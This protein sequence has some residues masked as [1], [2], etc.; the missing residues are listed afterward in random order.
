LIKKEKNESERERC[1]RKKRTRTHLIERWGRLLNH[2]RQQQTYA[3]I[4]VGRGR[5]SGDRRWQRPVVTVEIVYAMRI[6]IPIPVPTKT[7]VIKEKFWAPK[8]RVFHRSNTF[9]HH[10]R[11]SP[12]LSVFYSKSV[13]EGTVNP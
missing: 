11:G 6:P 1:K 8:P 9:F 2:R 3:I 13:F 12:G 10:L 4:Q 7:R 5:L